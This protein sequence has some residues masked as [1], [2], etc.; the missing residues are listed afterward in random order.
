MWGE[1][2]GVP[3]CVVCARLRGCGVRAALLDISPLAPAAFPTDRRKRLREMARADYMRAATHYTLLTLLHGAHSTSI[4]R[5]QHH[6]EVHQYT[7]P[8]QPRIDII[9]ERC[10]QFVI[11]YNQSRYLPICVGITRHVFIT[12]RLNLS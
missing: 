3:V 11:I 2:R 12:Y 6:G 4:H 1:V 10:T 5:T 7:R 9:M 8:A